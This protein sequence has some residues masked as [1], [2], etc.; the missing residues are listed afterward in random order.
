MIP[1]P[2]VSRSV[3]RAISAESTVEERASMP[4]L[5]HHGIGLGEPDRVEAAAVE[6]AGRLEHLAERLHREL[7]QPD[8][9]RRRHDGYCCGRR[10]ASSL[11]ALA[12]AVTCLSSAV[13]TWFDLLLDDRLQDPLAHRA[14]GPGD[15]DVRRPEHLRARRRSARA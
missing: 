7:H 12:A 13:S 14:D 8:P 4:C 5:R 2:I 1:Q 10:T 6:R 15:R 9:E 3:S 11:A